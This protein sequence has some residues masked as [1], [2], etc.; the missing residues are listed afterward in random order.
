MLNRPIEKE[1][2]KWLDQD[3]RALL[4]SGA[5]QVGKTSSIRNALENAPGYDFHEINFLEQP[6]FA[7]AVSDAG[8]AK[9]LLARLS[10]MISAPLKKH[11]AI[12]FFDEVQECP[13]LVTMI[14]FLVDEGSYRYVLSGSLLGVE[15]SGIRSTPVGYLTIL[16]MYPLTIREFYENV[17]IGDNTCS[18]VEASFREQYPVDDFINKRLLDLFHLYLIVGGMPA[19]VQAYIDTNDIQRV[20]EIQRD[21]VRLYKEDFSKYDK[22]EK[23][24]LTDIYDAIPAQLEEKNRRFIV[25]KIAGK[26]NFDRVE[27][28]FLWLKNAGVALPVYNV[29]EPAVPLKLNEKRNLFKLFMSDVGLLMSY[30]PNAVKLKILNGEIDVNMGGIYENVVAEELAAHGYPLYYY[31]GK[32][33]GEIDFLLEYNGALLP[34][35]VK[36]G[37]EYKKHPALSVLFD[38]ENYDIPKAIVLCEGNVETENRIAY[39]PIYMAMCIREAPLDNPIVPFDLT[40]LN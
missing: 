10:L 24:L 36:S 35:E 8:D 19:A 13:E 23:F 28:K 20:S 32:K 40:G 5:R 21:I 11:Q 17:G 37:K 2:R 29:T 1:I 3:T 16:D 15:L 39:L 27:N 4:V 9:T 38:V 18:L 12:I 34:L 30:Y 7:A 22:K 25:S 33:T 26:I 6:E 31:N 14:K